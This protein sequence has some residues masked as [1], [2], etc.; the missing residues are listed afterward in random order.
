[1]PGLLDSFPTLKSRIKQYE[2]VLPHSLIDWENKIDPVLFELSKTSGVKKT[3]VVLDNKKVA[4]VGND[5]DFYQFL[6]TKGREHYFTE[7]QLFLYVFSG[8]N[9]LAIL[10]RLKEYPDEAGRSEIEA[11][12]LAEST[13]AASLILINPEKA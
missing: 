5:E 8:L 11:F 6:K 1:M 7:A 4:F 10:R 2:K 9:D 3:K 13:E 12:W